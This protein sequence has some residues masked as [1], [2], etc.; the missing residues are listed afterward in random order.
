MWAVGT[1]SGDFD[2]QAINAPTRE[3]AIQAYA[4]ERGHIRCENWASDRQGPCRLPCDWCNAEA[5]Q[6]EPRGNIDA[7]RVEA[8]DKVRHMRR[9][10]WLKAGY[11]T[12]CDWC[13]Y[14]CFAESGAVIFRG[15]VTCEDCRERKPWRMTPRAAMSRA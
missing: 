1:D 3:A 10:H 11:G 14:E 12:T 13:D 8:W 9:M 5:R 4:I 6:D 2:W 7:E 15:K